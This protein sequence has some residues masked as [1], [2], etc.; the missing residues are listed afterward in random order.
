[1]R[2]DP[3]QTRKHP[4]TNWLIS[5]QHDGSFSIRLLDQGGE[6]GRSSTKY[7]YV[8]RPNYVMMPAGI[9]IILGVHAKFTYR[10]QHKLKLT[11]RVQYPILKGSATSICTS[12][13]GSITLLR[14][15]AHTRQKEREEDNKS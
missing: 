1:M 9:Q 12:I 6:H 4:I 5:S 11:M 8:Y 14:Q 10:W 13:S 7:K 15:S 3:E 2:H